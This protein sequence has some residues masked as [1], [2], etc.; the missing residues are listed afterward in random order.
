[1]QM[2]PFCDRVYDESEHSSCPY[3]SGELACGHGEIKVKDCPNCGGIMYWDGYWE[4][5]D[6]DHE[7]HTGEDDYDSIME[8]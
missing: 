1:M 4:C 7:I 6:C 2:C 3:C 5:S 8:D